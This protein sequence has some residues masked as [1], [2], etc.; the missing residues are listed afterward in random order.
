LHYDIRKF[1]YTAFNPFVTGV[2]TRLAV[3]MP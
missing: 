2:L 3:I 1:N